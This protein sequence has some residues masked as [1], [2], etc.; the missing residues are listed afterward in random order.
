M[1]CRSLGSAI[2]GLGGLQSRPLGLHLLANILVHRGADLPGASFRLNKTGPCSASLPAFPNENSDFQSD[3]EDI[4]RKA[5]EEEHNVHVCVSVPAGAHE[6]EERTHVPRR[7][8]GFVTVVCVCMCVYGRER[9]RARTCAEPSPHV[10]REEREA[11]T[12]T[13]THAHTHAYTHTHTHI[14][15]QGLAVSVR[16][17]PI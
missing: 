13:H 14:Y 17:S 10:Q 1:L 3:A 5:Q 9:A 11:H 6:L 7:E 16:L 4:W 12:C 2:W 15:I 8:R